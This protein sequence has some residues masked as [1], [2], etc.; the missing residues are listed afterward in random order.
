MVQTRLSQI[1]NTAIRIASGLAGKVGIFA[2]TCVAL[3]GCDAGMVGSDVP[4]ISQ[5]IPALPV[6]V[7]SPANS[8]LAQSD[9]FLTGLNS[10]PQT[11]AT[12]ADSTTI[13]SVLL[14]TPAILHLQQAE[15]RGGLRVMAA[16]DV[17][18]GDDQGAGYLPDLVRLLNASECA[19]EMV[20][21]QQSNDYQGVSV[22]HEGYRDHTAGHYLAGHES[23]SGS[24]A[25]IADAVSY[26]APDLV[27]MHLGATDLLMG[28]SVAS[29]L[30]DIESVIDTIFEYKPD[31]VVAVASVIA[32]SGFERAKSARQ[33]NRQ[34]QQTVLTRG[35]PL[36]TTVDVSS[37]FSAAMMHV[38][39]NIPNEAG[40]RYIAE[41]L[42]GSLFA[43]SICR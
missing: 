32:A 9:P 29:T 42:S 19:F 12:A 2:L 13:N 3:T 16:G 36:L 20:G 41:A 8:S 17:V 11:A 37:G 25:G 18:H 4:A 30:A 26:Q 10:L 21:S 31:T 34:L 15:A 22:A 14:S 35:N 27:I 38:D 43:P 40:N 33:L 24:N 6:D 7:M 23:S 5:P 1:K 28:R 39:T